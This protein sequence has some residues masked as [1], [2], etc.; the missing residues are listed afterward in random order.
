MLFRIQD[1]SSGPIC[2]VT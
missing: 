1:F 2:F